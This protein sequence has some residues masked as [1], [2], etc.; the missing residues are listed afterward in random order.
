MPVHERYKSFLNDQRQFFDELI[1]EDWDLYRSDEWD[2]A[3]S[4]EIDRLFEVFRPATILDVGCGCGFH[5]H[6]MAQ[7]PFV[8]SVDAIDY[9]PK[10]VER[11][12]IAYPHPKVRRWTSNFAE[13]DDRK[14]YDMVVS[15][16]VIEHLDDPAGFLETCA[17]M[18]RVG[19]MVA[20]FTPNRLRIDNA[21]RM[22]KGIPPQLS[23][24]MH[25]KEYVPSELAKLAKSY[26][27]VRRKLIGVGFSGYEVFGVKS[28]SLQTRMKLGDWL[29][30][31]ASA[32][33]LVLERRE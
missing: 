11:A 8:E 22:V 13:L 25:F 17:R 27:L 15:F 32:F 12:N 16:Q 10:S 30:K 7:H 33:G 1:T 3:R 9:S 18:C 23:D 20:I 24:P 14:L 2:Q 21:V 4:Y 19:G 28:L 29:P 6:A 26:G 5:D 31:L